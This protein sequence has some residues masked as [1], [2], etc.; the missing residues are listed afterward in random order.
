MEV[1]NE[2]AMKF[3]P[4]YKKTLNQSDYITHLNM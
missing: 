2:T 4:L 1:F 3:I